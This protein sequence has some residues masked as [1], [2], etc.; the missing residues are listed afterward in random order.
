M[1]GVVKPEGCGMKIEISTTKLRGRLH[2][3]I[4]IIFPRIWGFFEAKAHR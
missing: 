3:K 1:Y 2:I 4:E